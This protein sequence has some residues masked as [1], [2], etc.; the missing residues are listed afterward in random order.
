MQGVAIPWFQMSQCTISFYSWNQ[1]KRVIEIKFGLLLYESFQEHLFKLQQ[2]NS[3]TEYYTEFISLANHTNIKPHDVL[4]DCFIN[5]LASR[6]KLDVCRKFS[7]IIRRQIQPYHQK[8]FASK[9]ISSIPIQPKPNLP[10]Q[11]PYKNILPLLL[12]NPN[13]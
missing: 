5:I 6:K 3:V 2:H 9:P 1:L 7:Q 4:R 10:M 12:P 8:H 13:Y 11:L